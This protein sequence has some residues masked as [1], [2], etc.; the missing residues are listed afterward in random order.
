MILARV[1]KHQ[2]YR[3]ALNQPHLGNKISSKVIVTKTR[4]DVIKAV[5]CWNSNQD[6][7][8]YV[9]NYI[10]DTDRL[11]THEPS[12]YSYSYKIIEET[13]FTDD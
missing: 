12:D 5:E 9:I 8:T 7:H 2:I 6:I 1:T 3:D 11:D 13:K 4:E 10:K